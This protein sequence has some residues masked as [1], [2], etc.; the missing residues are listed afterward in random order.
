VAGYEKRAPVRCACGRVI[1]VIGD[2]MSGVELTLTDEK[3]KVFSTTTNVHG[4]FC[5]G[6]I[7]KG[8]YKLR[9]KLRGYQIAERDIQITSSAQKC[10]P[11]IEVK[12][13]VRV[14]Q[15]GVYVKGVDK[16]SDLDSRS[17]N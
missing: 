11:R 7:P 15:T 4:L 8:N 12:L 5:F 14:C 13:D 16:R 10:S 9:A 2:K 3:D 17:R 6:A 1:N